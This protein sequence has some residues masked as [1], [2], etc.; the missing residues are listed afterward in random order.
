MRSQTKANQLKLKLFDIRS[1]QL[2]QE[3][4]DLTDEE[5]RA[6]AKNLK[7]ICNEMALSKNELVDFA[8][9]IAGIGEA[10]DGE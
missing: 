6:L 1:R 3:L 7:I 10:I 9:R 5:K 4:D 2:L 8:E